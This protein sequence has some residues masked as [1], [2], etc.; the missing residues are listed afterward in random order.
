MIHLS[1]SAL[2]FPD[3]KHGKLGTNTEI[4]M[5]SFGALEGMAETAPV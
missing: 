5:F 4:T 3:T 1:H 2:L